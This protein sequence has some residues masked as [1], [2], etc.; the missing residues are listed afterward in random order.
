[1][2]TVE[3]LM[4]SA[5]KAYVAGKPRQARDDLRKLTNVASAL[6]RELT[7]DA[8]LLEAACDFAIGIGLA[9]DLLDS[10]RFSQ[11]IQGPY[12]LRIAEALSKSTDGA[13]RRRQVMDAAGKF[14]DPS[15]LSDRAWYWS[16]YGDVDD[17]ISPHRALEHYGTADMLFQRADDFEGELRN[18]LKLIHITLEVG[19]S[20]FVASLFLEAE[21]LAMRVD[22]EALREQLSEIF[23]LHAE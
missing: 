9:T 5:I 1:M 3:S 12:T 15:R 4:T 17:Q 7:T 23:V 20:A 18:K 2:H 14:I 6:P 11:P 19:E 8:R 21:A 13:D 16:Y 10:L 22:N